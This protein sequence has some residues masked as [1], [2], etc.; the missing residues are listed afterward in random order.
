LL[1]VGT[2]SNLVIKRVEMSPYK[3]LEMVG[4]KSITN[5]VVGLCIR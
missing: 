1:V 4:Q 3:P 2:E 5:E